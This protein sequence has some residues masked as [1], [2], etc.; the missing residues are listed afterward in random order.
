M[1]LGGTDQIDAAMVLHV[2][3]EKKANNGIIACSNTRGRKL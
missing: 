2:A 1:R 3:N